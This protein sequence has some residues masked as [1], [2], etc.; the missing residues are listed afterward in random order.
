MKLCDR[1]L[2]G[3]CPGRRLL[4]AREHRDVLDAQTPQI[5]DRGLG[6]GADRVPN[7]DCGDHLV[8]DG[9]QGEHKSLV[10]QA[11]D[12]RAQLVGRPHAGRVHGPRTSHPHRLGIDRGRRAQAGLGQKAGG[13]RNIEPH[14]PGMRDQQSGD[15]V[16]GKLLDGRR[17]PHH[18][19]R[20][21]A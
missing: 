21:K 11:F 9:H 4:V 18:G 13:R 14:L 12:P 17:Q 7:A 3:R 5:A 8:A 15:G 10:A 20:G 16:L 19:R 2:R 6:R 1:Q